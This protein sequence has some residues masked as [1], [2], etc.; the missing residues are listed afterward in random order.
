MRKSAA[1]EGLSI[2]PETAVCLGAL[3]MLLA[4]GEIHAH[5]R[6]VV[7]NT[8]AAQKYPEAIHEMIPLL[9]V[10]RPIDWRRI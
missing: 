1:L 9:D 5:E 10:Q 4:R 8:G 2:C 7:F 6:I 3:E